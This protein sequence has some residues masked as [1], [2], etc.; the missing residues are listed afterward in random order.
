[1]IFNACMCSGKFKVLTVFLPTFYR[2]DINDDSHYAR[3]V[4]TELY[5]L[6]M[7]DGSKYRV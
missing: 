1:M 2:A 5:S 7:L 6:D 4:I 3:I